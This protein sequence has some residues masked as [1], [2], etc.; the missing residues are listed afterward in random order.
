MHT[1]V[2]NEKEYKLPKY[3]SLKMWMKVMED[4][5]SADHII[6]A[7][8]GCS[9]E[10]AELVPDETKQ[11]VAMFIFQLMQP[12]DKSKK[13]LDRLIE[14]DSMTLGQFID[15]DVFYDIGTEKTIIGIVEILFDADNV[16][17]WNIAHVTEG[18]ARFQRWKQSFYFNYRNLFSAPEEESEDRPMKNKVAKMWY[19]IVMV[20]A[21]GDMLKIEDVTESGLTECFNWLAWNKDQQR[22]LQE[23]TK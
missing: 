19:D 3:I 23:L 4:V 14:F 18:M 15:L 1:L 11:L 10:E 8:L 12:N 20:I 21:Q 5:N 22:K 2:I 17:N 9:K 7:V 6:S 13:Y 16:E